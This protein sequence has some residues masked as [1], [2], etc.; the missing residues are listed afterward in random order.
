MLLDIKKTLKNRNFQA[1]S[2]FALSLLIFNIAFISSHG[3]AR[4]FWSSLGYLTLYVIC[5]VEG[6]SLS[7]IGLSRSRVKSGLKYGFY[8]I[9]AI[10]LLM[11]LAFFI[12]K[13]IFQ[14]PRYH[15]N[16]STALAA[17]LELVP[18]KTVIF[19][20]V[21]FRGILPAIALRIK[22]QQRFATIVSSVAFG[23]WHVF[24]ASKIGNYD[25]AGSI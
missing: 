20:E 12:D 23:L 6:L 19:E 8:V 25:L 1:L 10:L 9:A 14:D 18:L 5:R 3:W 2:L 4:V 22:N 16:L 24:S 13:T 7:S 15:H 21:A 11:L 17:A